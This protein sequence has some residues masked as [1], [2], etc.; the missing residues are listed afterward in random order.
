VWQK[1][2]W[3]QLPLHEQAADFVTPSGPVSKQLL[4]ESAWQKLSLEHWQKLPTR[5]GEQNPPGPQSA[6]TTQLLSVAHVF[7]AVSELDDRQAQGAL[8]AQS[9]SLVQSSYEQE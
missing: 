9:E 4:P 8:P 7:A 1:Y 6:S 5:L 3:P 2:P